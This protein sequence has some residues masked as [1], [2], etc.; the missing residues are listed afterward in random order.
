VTEIREEGCTRL[1]SHLSYDKRMHDQ[2]IR[3]SIAYARSLA[4]SGILTKE[5]EHKIITGLR[6]VGKE[7]ADG[8]VCL[9]RYQVFERN[10]DSIHSL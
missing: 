2:D 5:E 9:A 3:G 10:T 8:T 6:E 1:I 4:L 7:W